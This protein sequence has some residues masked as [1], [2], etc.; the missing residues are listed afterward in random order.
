VPE[1]T[2]ETVK[3][4]ARL[5]N[6]KL[7]EDE[8]AR[9]AEQLEKILEYIHTLTRLDTKGIPETAHALPLHNVWREDRVLSGLTPGQ[10]R[11]AAPDSQDDCFRVPRII[12]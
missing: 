4:I 5:A 6:I 8:T 3:K 1:I 9:F 2:D 11:A 7:S 10:A 12:E